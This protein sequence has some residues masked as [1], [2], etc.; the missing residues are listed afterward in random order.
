MQHKGAYKFSCTLIFLLIQLAVH[1][2]QNPNK[3]DTFFLAKKKGLLGRFGKSIS[4]STPDIEPQ[5]VENQFLKFKGKFIR[6]IDIVRLGFE[7]NIYDTTQVKDNFG[8]RVARRLHKNSKDRTISR[9][10]F[11]KE[12]DKLYPYLLAD[13][14]RYLRELVFLSD[15]RILVDYT[16][17]GTD[18][19]DI[20]VLTKDVFSIGGQLVINNQYKGRAELKE[21][22][23]NG[24]GSRVMISGFYEKDRHPQRGFSAE[25]AQ[26]NIGGRFIDWT[27][28]FQNYRPAFNSDRNEETYIY[29]R[30]EKPLVTPYIPST[31]ALEAAFYRT[32]NA[33]V[34]DSLYRSDYRY[35]FYN[36]DGWF[37]YSLDSKRLLYA[38]K[39]IKKHRFIALRGF[40]QRFIRTPDIT[41]KIFD[42]RY[43][44]F[45]GV[46]TSLNIFRQ[47]YY[48]TNFVYGF[49]RSEDI[50]EGFT[51][52]FTGGFVN[53]QGIKRPYGG[54][55]AQFTDFRK[56]GFYSSYTFRLGG[57][58]H[59]GRFEDAEML[60][61]LEHFTRLNKLGR[62]WFNRSFI[63]TG[64]TAQVNPVLNTPLFLN[65]TYGLLYFD[66]GSISADLRASVKTESVFY[67]TKKILGFRLAP[68]V[69]FD[70]SLLKPSKLG[71][72]K[73]DGFT[74]VGGGIRT[75]NENLVF[76]TIELRGYYFPRTNGEMKAWKVELNSNIRFKYKSSFISRPDFIIAN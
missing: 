49:G 42:Y 32:S 25:V 71:L 1:A 58:Y 41:K 31:G 26:R 66:N 33:Y 69:F 72:G 29:S 11:F 74:A 39:E 64:I 34:S 9:N 18:S 68:F 35:E 3:P 2:Q 67:N 59:N 55:D 54:I 24:S 12:G 38:N 21:E 75:R 48:K 5:K 76:G 14:E 62:T 56:T 30:L 50:P 47:S 27:T 52:S 36:L 4:T 53:K 17:N 23:F 57:Y 63:S 22:N 61:N 7:Y 51:V 70:A 45:T 20:V 19:V 37:G 8:I 46:L 65:S 28:G 40:N 73:S 13:N 60:F 16:E 15:A 10:L 44:D 6:Y 43:T